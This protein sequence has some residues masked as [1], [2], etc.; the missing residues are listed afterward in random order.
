M[1]ALPALRFA[2][3][4]VHVGEEIERRRKATRMS[5]TELAALI[6]VDRSH[7]YDIITSPTC[8]SGKLRQCCKA[9]HFNFFNLLAAD[10]DVELGGVAGAAS[11]TA[12]EPPAVYGRRPAE[13]RAPLRLVIEVDPSDQEAQ[14]AA[15]RMAESMQPKPAAPA[16]SRDKEQP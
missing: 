13:H 3:M 1:A 4:A 16:P 8:D 5:K 9:L 14:A 15:I 12:A 7:I 6:G 10:M 11:S 2:P